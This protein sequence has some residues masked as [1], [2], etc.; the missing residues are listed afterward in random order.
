MFIGCSIVPVGFCRRLQD[1]DG[2][3][4]GFLEGP[5]ESQWTSIEFLEDFNVA[6]VVLFFCGS[7]RK[8]QDL[9]LKPNLEF[10]FE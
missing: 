5:V 1:F 10:A 3:S 7:E 8:W 9:L 6:S 4:T 2:I